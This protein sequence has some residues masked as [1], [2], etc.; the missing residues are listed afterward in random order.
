MRTRITRAILAAVAVVILGLGIPLAVVV[1]RF[2]QN[3]A[4]TELERRAA[5]TLNEITLPID[6]LSLERLM[7]EPDLPGPFSI[8][9]RTGRLVFGH[10]PPKPEPVVLSAL[11]G[12][13]ASTRVR[14]KMVAA[15]P[16]ID[17]SDESVVG[18]VRVT[19]SQAVVDQEVTRAWMIMATAVA[20]AL[21]CAAA[22]A[23]AQASRLAAPV[24]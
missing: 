10:G 2:Y 20:V 5:A 3:T 18:V 11:N 19:E 6:S 23:R 22:L 8:Y 4:M 21:A 15:A 16:I 7:N 1:Q 24:I 17:H 9:D 14:N 12:R 13:G